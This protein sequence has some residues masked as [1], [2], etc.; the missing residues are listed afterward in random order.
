[1]NWKRKLGVKLVALLM[2]A[3]LG[4]PAPI[5]AQAVDSQTTRLN[6]EGFEVSWDAVMYLPTGCSRYE[7]RYQ[8]NTGR[9]LL[10]VGFELN[11][12]YGDSITYHSLIGAPSG[13]SGTWSKQICVSALPTTGPYRMKVYIEDYSFRGGNTSQQTVDLYFTDRNNSTPSQRGWGKSF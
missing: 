13:G 11:S 4:L 9:E 6:V 10:K 7:F 1:M 12:V 8:N 3:G 5:A 2:V